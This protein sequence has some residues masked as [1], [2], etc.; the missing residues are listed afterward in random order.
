MPVHH[1]CVGPAV[2]PLAWWWRASREWRISWYPQTRQQGKLP[3][4]PEGQVQPCFGNDKCYELCFA[5]LDKPLIPNVGKEP[6]KS[7]APWTFGTFWF[8]EAVIERNVQVIFWVRCSTLCLLSIQ[9]HVRLTATVPGRY[10]WGFLTPPAF[11]IAFLAAFV[12]NCLS[13]A[14]LPVDLLAICLVRAMVAFCCND[15]GW[16]YSN[17]DDWR[18]SLLWRQRLIDDCC[19]F[20]APRAFQRPTI[21]KCHLAKLPICQSQWLFM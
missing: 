18:L 14:L 17:G 4:P 1:K 15:D 19:F 12:A 6:C 10:R 2:C 11:G 20:C 8:L 5:N 13:G 3:K 16:K 7:L 21:H 9:I